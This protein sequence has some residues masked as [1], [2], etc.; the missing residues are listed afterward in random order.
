MLVMIKSA[1]D[2]TEGQRGVKLARDMSAEIVLLQNGVY[3]IQGRNLEDTGFVGPVHVLEDDR[4]LRGVKADA[5]EKNI[6]DITYDRLIDL[7]AE[8][9]KVIGM[10]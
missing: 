1:P 9:D 3:F 2:T 10:F 5:P 6:N 7:M 8:G 4:R